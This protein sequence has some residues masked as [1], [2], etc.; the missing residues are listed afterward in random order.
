MSESDSEPESSRTVSFSPTSTSQF[1]GDLEIID[2]HDDDRPTDDDLPPPPQAKKGKDLS[3]FFG[4]DVESLQS[5]TSAGRTPVSPMSTSTNGRGGGRLEVD[6]DKD[7]ARAL[8]FTPAVAVEDLSDGKQALMPSDSAA[9]VKPS[10]PPKKSN[11]TLFNGSDVAY[12]VTVHNMSVALL[13]DE[14]V[15]DAGIIDF[16]LA[17]IFLHVDSSNIGEEIKLRR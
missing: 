10:E 6:G 4:E 2:E 12:R 16:N 5:P 11:G 14:K 13:L 7:I 9:A 15:L 3:K 17:D 8:K 1:K